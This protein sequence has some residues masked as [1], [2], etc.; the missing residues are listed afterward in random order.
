M[1]SPESSARHLKGI[2]C[3]R[4]SIDS[5]RESWT[6]CRNIHFDVKGLGRSLFF[7]KVVSLCTGLEETK[8]L[9][10]L[11]GGVESAVV[12][13]VEPVDIEEEELSGECDEM[14]VSFSFFKNWE[15]EGKEKHG[16][17]VEDRGS[18]VLTARFRKK[19]VLHD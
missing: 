5:S 2:Q 8:E 7:G 12:T 9:I 6:R 11:E 1:R 15:R 10:E 13:G 17:G 19:I 16:N 14:E 4:V 3:L 18:T